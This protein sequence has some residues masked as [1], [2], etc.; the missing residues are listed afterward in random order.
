MKTFCEQM[1]GRITTARRIL[2]FFK[3]DSKSRRTIVTPGPFLAIFASSLL[4]AC[5]GIPYGK[6]PV[7]ELTPLQF[8]EPLHTRAAETARS[9]VPGNDAMTER[10]A[11]PAAPEQARTIAMVSRRGEGLSGEWQGML[12]QESSAGDGSMVALGRFLRV[13]L[14]Q[15]GT[16]ISG[17]GE[18]STGERLKISGTVE[19]GRSH[20]IVENVTYGMASRFVGTVADAEI[21]VHFTHGGGE[22]DVHGVATLH[23]REN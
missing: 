19:K 11:V 17:F 5:T 20:G 7:T 13:S 23:R 6:A 2:L 9:V 12:S 18:V 15:A 22:A 1:L 10:M 8:L 16:M 21:V 3:L 14:Q 4:C